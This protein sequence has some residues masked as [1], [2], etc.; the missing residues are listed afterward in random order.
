V[1]I[2]RVGQN[3]SKKPHCNIK[4]LAKFCARK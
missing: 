2:Y 3:K 1:K 4:M